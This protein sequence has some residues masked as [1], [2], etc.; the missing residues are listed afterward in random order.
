MLRE[1]NIQSTR[2]NEHILSVLGPGSLKRGVARLMRRSRRAFR[3]FFL[4][5]SYARYYSADIWEREYREGYDLSQAAEDARYAVLASLIRRYEG[6]G[7][8]LDAG[9]GDGL[10]EARFRALSQTAVVGVDYSATAIRRACERAIPACEFICDDFRTLRRNLPFSVVVFNETLYYVED[11]LEALAQ[12]EHR[13]AGGGVIIV[14]MFRTL[15]TAR[16]WRRIRK[17]HAVLQHVT[18]GDA[19]TG[20]KWDLSVLGSPTA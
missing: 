15:V 8:I 11:Y 1:R 19:G 12:M 13:L 5:H 3:H 14:S 10:L 2:G 6:T 17:R 4:D 16:M 20:V 7:P 18:L 9:C